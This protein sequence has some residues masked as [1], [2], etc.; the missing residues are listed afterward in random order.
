[1]NIVF[2]CFNRE[3]MNEKQKKSRKDKVKRFA[4][5]GLATIGGGTL[6]GEFVTWL[7]VL[8]CISNFMNLE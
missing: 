2:V 3:E 6:I 1:M 5:I 4:L 8:H 7:S